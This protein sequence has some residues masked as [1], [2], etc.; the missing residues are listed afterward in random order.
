MPPPPESFEKRQRERKKQR[1]REEK[2]ERRRQRSAE[3]R[4]GRGLGG[5]PVQIVLRRGGA[6][7]RVEGDVWLSTLDLAAAQG[8]TPGGDPERGTWAR[9]AGRAV[10][11]DEARALARS[12]RAQLPTLSDEPLPF[13]HHDFGEE[14]TEA[15]LARRLAGEPVREE[16]IRSAREILGGDPKRDVAELAEFLEGGAFAF[17]EVDG[18]A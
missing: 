11:A 5:G 8:W 10:E 16:E 9:P 12:L 7:H 4:G 1:K 6:E 17:D 14:H 2:R 13:T 18:G 3:K 15:L